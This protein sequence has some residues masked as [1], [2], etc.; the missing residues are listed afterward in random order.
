MEIKN[1]KNKLFSQKDL[2]VDESLYLFELIMSGKL[3]DIE[4]TKIIDLYKDKN[5]EMEQK[6]SAIESAINN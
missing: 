2:K 5:T 4:I 6:L 3:S 1:L